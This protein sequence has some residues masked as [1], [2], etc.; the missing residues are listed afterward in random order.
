MSL[1][2]ETPGRFKIPRPASGLRR[3]AKRTLARLAGLAARRAG[4]PALRILTYHRVNASHP[5]DRLSVPPE[6]FARQM[7]ALARSGRPVVGLERAVAALRGEVEL[8]RGAVVITFD[9]GFRDNH[10]HALP[11][12]RSFGLPASF[13]VPSALVESGR[14]LERYERCCAEDELMTWNEVRA[15]AAAG[16]DIGGHGRT[17]KELAC[18]DAATLHDETHG[19]H[20]EIAERLSLAPRFFCYPRG[21][22]SPSVRRA[23]AEAGFEA[24]LTVAPGAN[25]RGVDLFGLS[26]TEVAADDTLADFSRKLEGG[27]DGWHRLLR[28]SHS[29]AGARANDGF[30]RHQ[31]G[32]SV[33]R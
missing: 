20:R 10:D 7:E 8:P 4:D 18:L 3:A 11:V 29:L 12:L 21:S 28:A 32:R 27:F 16:H 1:S 17:H 5:G 25:S 19:C 9:D 26:R 14:T 13:F 30:P 33:V 31:H 24:A 6:T 2:E 22:E 23:V 15:V